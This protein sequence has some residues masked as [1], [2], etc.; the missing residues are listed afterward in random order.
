MAIIAAAPIKAQEK[1][2]ATFKAFNHLDVGVTLGST[3]LG[4]ELESP[5]GNSVRFR[6]G[7]EFMPRFD[8][9]MHFEVQSFDANGKPIDSQIDMMSSTMYE[10]TGYKVD[11]TIDMIGRPK[12]WNFKF[13]IDVFP[14]RNKHWHI[15]AGFHWGPSKI[16]EAFNTT[17]DAPS[18]FAVGMYNHLYDVAYN[19]RVLGINQPLVTLSTSFGPYDLNLDPIIMDKLLSFGRMGV[20][21]GNYSHD[22]TD[23]DGNVIHK[24]GDPYCMVPDENSMVRAEVR[25]NSFK[26]YLGFGYEGRLGKH[27]D[28]YKIGFD[29]GLLFWG[30]TPSIIT[31]DGTNLSKDVND[32]DGRV[33]TYVDLI[34]GVK[35]FPV[36]NLRISRRLF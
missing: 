22:I 29:C 2:E 14:F 30:G 15:T 1:T 28:R 20:R 36:I 18:L 3:G 25:V 8:Y 19:N 32:I 13:L 27:K 7:L 21:V 35:A 5:F 34:S 9:D 33:G 31:H 11:R 6:A 10:M 12:M 4:I 23:E 16:G 17:E 24:A 26:P